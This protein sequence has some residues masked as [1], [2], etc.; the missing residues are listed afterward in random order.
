MPA[1]PANGVTDWNTKQKAYVDVE[2]ELDGTHKLVFDIDGV[3]TRVYT[4]Y[5]TGNLD[6]D[7]TTVFAHGVTASRILA[8]S[9]ICYDDNLNT[10]CT[11]DRYVGVSA[12]DTFRLEFD[13]T[14]LIFKQIGAN[15]Q[16][17]VYRVKIDYY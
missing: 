12:A 8:A 10:Y 4:K 17:N 9:A 5:L 11:A 1:W 14:N 13:A 2:H 16:G 3:K 7:D 6:A 15:L